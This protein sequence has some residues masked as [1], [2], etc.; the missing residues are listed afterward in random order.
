MAE[1]GKPVKSRHPSDAGQQIV[2]NACGLAGKGCP[3]KRM[4]AC[5]GRD[6]GVMSGTKVSLLR[7]GVKWQENMKNRIN[8]ETQMTAT[9]LAGASSTMPK[10]I[11]PTL[12]WPKLSKLV[13]RLQIRIAKAERE[14]KRGKVR[15]LQRLLTCSFAAKCLAVK[16]VTSNTGSKT[17]GVDGEIW[18]T[19]HQKT[20]GI[21]GLKRHGYKPQ[22][23]RRIYIPKKT[24]IKE[25]RP[26]SI[27]T[28]IDRA[29]QALYL[30]SI[31]PIVE[32]WA[33]P[34]AYGF[35]LKRST[36]DAR[37]QCF[38]ALCRS[39]SASWILEGDIKSCFCRIDHNYLLEKVPMDKT[40][41]RK[42]LKSGFM[43]KNQLYPTTAGTPQGGII[44]PALAVM[45]L[46]GLE[47]KLRAC[48]E[49][50]RKKE[51]INMIAYADDFVVT[52]ASKELLEKK[53]MP[54]LVQALA[55]VGLELSTTKTKITH[56][57][58]GFDFL[59]FNIRKYDGKLLTRPSKAGIKR[60]LKVIKEIIK[61]GVALP[62]EQ[63]IHSLNNRLTGWVNYYRSSVSSK[64]FSMIDSVIFQS[65]MRWACK[66]H[67]RKGKQWIVKKYFT[68][69]GGDHWRFYCKTKDKWG[70]E[71]LLYLKNAADTKI[72]RHIKIKSAAT[73]FNPLYKEYF[74]QR[75]S[76]R[77][78]RMIISNSTGLRVI[79]SY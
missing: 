51:K 38:H 37:E 77:I 30:L 7:I 60:F 19:N 17:P 70:K 78:R 71:K 10:D 64:A 66:R 27:P 52:A 11:W 9:L 35:R 5:N 34:N 4:L 15:A 32:E 67:A 12:E 44:S 29:Q 75:D 26:L 49:R 1:R 21:F 74:E 65:L 68:S 16:R 13:L 28:M 40:I 14:G 2:R 6:T 56:I 54:I 36:H 73:P 24:G 48:T 39:T 62:I 25:L 42:F 45:A 33:D 23:L 47:D 79:Q 50:Q 69:V 22:P 59:G 61:N 72:R 76:E 55:K 57:D 18:Q 41:L 43:E 31:E 3:R 8:E 63:M 46:S 20:Q 53:V 58:D